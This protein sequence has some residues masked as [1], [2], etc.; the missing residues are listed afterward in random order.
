VSADLLFAEAELEDLA[1]SDLD[2]EELDEFFDLDSEELDVLDVS[3]FC[4]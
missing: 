1:D 4:D 3:S 2:D